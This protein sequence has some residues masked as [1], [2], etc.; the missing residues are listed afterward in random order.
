M[1]AK[2]RA[3]CSRNSA[4]APRISDNV[5]DSLSKPSEQAFAPIIED[6]ALLLAVRAQRKGGAA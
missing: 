1:S 5:K 2:K 6:I 4:L 3:L